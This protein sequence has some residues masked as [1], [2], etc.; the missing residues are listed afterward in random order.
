MS[1]AN[2]AIRRCGLQPHRSQGYAPLQNTPDCNRTCLEAR[3]V[4]NRTYLEAVRLQTA[5]T[6]KPCGCKPHLLGSR[7]VANRTYLGAVRLQ[8][9]PTI[10]NLRK[11][12]RDRL[13]QQFGDMGAGW[14]GG[15]KE[16]SSRHIFRL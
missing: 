6:W 1:R 4:A 8:T 12:L 11:K 13:N 3:A 9:A 14:Q 16:Y 15:D 2:F 10:T 7:A 5:P